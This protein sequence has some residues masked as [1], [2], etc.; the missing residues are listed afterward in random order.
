MPHGRN[1]KE[2]VSPCFISLP[3]T[4]SDPSHFCKLSSPI[5]FF[6]C[7]LIFCTL[8]FYLFKRF[9]SFFNFSAILFTT[10]HC[11]LCNRSLCRIFICPFSG[12]CCNQVLHTWSRHKVLHRPFPIKNVK[13]QLPVWGPGSLFKLIQC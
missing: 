11:V 4:Q 7:L 10:R 5:Y 13:V 9:L 1:M 2:T 3:Y 6:F 12:S 8:F